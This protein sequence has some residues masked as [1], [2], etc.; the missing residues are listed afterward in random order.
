[1]SIKYCVFSKNLKYI[2]NFG[3]SRFPIV[4]SVCTQWQVKHQRC[5][6]TGRVQ[7]NHNILRKNTIFNEH[8]VYLNYVRDIS[9]PYILFR[10]SAPYQRLRGKGNSLYHD[11]GNKAAQHVLISFLICI[12]DRQAAGGVRNIGDHD[13]D[14]LPGPGVLGLDVPRPDPGGGREE[15]LLQGHATQIHGSH[16]QH[17]TQASLIDN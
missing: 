6:R 3:F 11:I 12:D 15:T 13:C 14:P 8:P 2:P 9:P 5:S 4:V 7:K 16:P 17:T 10:S 1:M